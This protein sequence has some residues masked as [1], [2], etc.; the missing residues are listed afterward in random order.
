MK[1]KIFF[2][3]L[4]ALLALAPIASYGDDDR[5]S[6]GAVYAMTNGPEGNRIVAFDRD[7]FGRLTLDGT[8]DTGGLGIGGGIDPLASQNALVLSSNNRWLF[9]VNAGSDTISVFRVQR[10]GLKLVGAFESGGAIPVSLAS[11]HNLLY[12][13]NA[14][15]DGVAPNITGFRLNR[16]G[17]LVPLEGS[18]RELPGNGFHQVGFTPHGDRLVVTKG[19]ADADVLLVFAVDEDGLTDAAPTVSPSAGAVPFSFI[20]DRRGH[21]LVAEAGSGA[22]SS[23]AILDDNTLEIIDGSV[24]NGNLAT[25]WIVGTWYGAVFTAN[26]ASD[27]ISSY[28]VRSADG[29]LKLQKAIAGAGN[30]PID[31]AVSRNGRFLY[32]LNAADGT[33]GAFRISHNGGL[34]DLGTIEG[35]PPEYAQGIAAR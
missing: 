18:T 15:E 17:N 14:G 12:V 3:I 24:G 31:M 25:C 11:Y 7:G 4:A 29:S 35:L 32:A 23:Y 5:D 27:N 20:F 9:A 21:L 6:T 33:V 28:L 8:Y 22:V 34:E 13:L 2:V 26:T 16:R 1:C 10:H 30:K 19:G